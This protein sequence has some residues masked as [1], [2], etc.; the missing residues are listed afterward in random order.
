MIII[1]TR[2]TKKI[3]GQFPDR[4]LCASYQYRITPDTS[5]R[6]CSAF[7]RLYGIAINWVGFRLAILMASACFRTLI[8]LPGL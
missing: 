1:R 8:R 4:G 6:S 3:P 2:Q 5:C 7:G